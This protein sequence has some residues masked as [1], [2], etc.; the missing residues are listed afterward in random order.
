[1]I[2]QARLWPCQWLSR[3]WRG[4]QYSPCGPPPTR[5]GHSEPDSARPRPGPEPSK[6]ARARSWS[7]K[8][9]SKM[10]CQ[11]QTH[12]NGKDGV[13]MLGLL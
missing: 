7:L 11:Q 12:K 5:V 8:K 10:M 13:G 1:V 2:R 4:L 9:T 6:N 3:A